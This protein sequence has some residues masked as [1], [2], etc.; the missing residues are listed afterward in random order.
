M[1]KWALVSVFAAGLAV[2]GCG[3]ETSPASDGARSRAIAELA[4]HAVAKGRIPGL[5]VAV[6]RDGKLFQKVTL[7]ISDLATRRPVSGETPFQL[8]S[9]TKIFSSAAVILLVADGKLALDDRIGDRLAG[10]PA[11]WRGI[12]I[13]QLLSHT[14]GLPDIARETG[15]IDLV[16]DDWEK[17][18]PI[19]SG[20]P[21]Q[22]RPGHGWSYTQTNY[23]LL[24]RI[25]ERISGIGFEAFLETRLFRPLGMRNTFFPDRRRQCGGS[26]RRDSDG[27][28]ID[29]ADLAFPLYVHAAGGLCSS[30]DDLILWDAALD[31]GKL[32]PRALVEEAWTPA[33]LA[34]GSNA[35]I[36]G[37]MSYGLGWAIDTTAGNRWV[38]HSGGNSTAF[39]RYLDS[40]MSIIVLHNGV[41]DPDA[42]VSAIARAMVDAGDGGGAQAQLWD[43]AAAGDMAATQ[44]ALQSG[45]DLNALD[46]RT[47]R[48][49]RYALNWAAIND[50][51][52]IVR[53]LIAHGAAIDAPNRSGFTALHHAAEAGSAAAA[54]ALLAA[55]ADPARRNADG[56]TPEDVARRE[57]H[58]AVAGLLRQ[59]R[60]APRRGG[61]ATPARP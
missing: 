8:A 39:R 43:A 20:Q 47:S 42:I 48:N 5:A 33:R 58:M 44:A 21:F 54:Q 50:H 31:A 16:A 22:F 56:E 13:R 10:L 23:A 27:R 11:S 6:I 59:S 60:P 14:S 36:G 26:F 32:I 4:R 52:D 37:P 61:G 19:V 28:I 1:R 7:G 41:S 53:A 49:G 15:Q 51:P 38:G 45:A 12:T 40:H 30:L 35:K 34:D 17:A 18:L 24:Q 25:V 57:G 29:R 55:G 2:S 9:T 3:G 46:T